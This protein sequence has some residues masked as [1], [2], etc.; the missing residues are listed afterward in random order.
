VAWV[1]ERKDVLSVLFLML[2]L[3]AYDAYCRQ[4][5]WGRYFAVLGAMLMSLLAK[6][7]LVTL[8]VLLLLLDVWPLR[9]LAL[10]GIGERVSGGD[11]NDGRYQLRPVSAVI[12]EKLPLFVLSLLFSVITLW[13]QAPVIADG[14]A[15]PLMA[16]RVPN[17]VV[18][19]GWYLR[20]LVLPFG[21]HPA[22]LHPGR[23]GH[24]AWL[25]AVSAALV[26]LVG[27]VAWV[28]RHRQ[29][30]GIVGLAGRDQHDQRSSDAVDEVVNLAGQSTAGTTNTVVRRLD[31]GIVVI[32][33]SP[34]CGGRCSWRADER[35]RCWS[36]RR[37][38]SQ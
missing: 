29:P 35:G 20:A 36:R 21:L 2:S 27:I 12:G 33:P 24:P 30:W 37:P 3:L 15:M 38:P 32:R 5:S 25:V 28:G 19:T 8:P 16:V 26:C 6:A 31:A 17:A 14:T 22:Y 4:P 10:P 23:D 13:T 7:T 18:A 9:R 34:L 11:A 1:A